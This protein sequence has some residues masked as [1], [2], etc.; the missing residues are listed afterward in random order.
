MRVILML[1]SHLDQVYYYFYYRC[2]KYWNNYKSSDS[3][4]RSSSYFV[5]KF[6]FA[7]F[8]QFCQCW[9]LSTNERL[10]T[11]SLCS[12]FNIGLI[13]TNS[14][15][16]CSRCYSI[17]E[18]SKS[19]NSKQKKKPVSIR[20]ILKLITHIEQVNYYSYYRYVKYWNN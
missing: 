19:I 10:S 5:C 13:K 17:T 3:Y 18:K 1:V 2:V 6:K 14:N 4:C 8:I 15:D 12:G 20:V 7:F 16:M 9:F 11:C